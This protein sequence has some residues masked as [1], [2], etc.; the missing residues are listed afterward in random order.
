MHRIYMTTNMVNGKKYVGRCSKD[1]RWDEGYLGSGKILKQ[2]IRKYGY[3]NFKR[4]VLEE[5]PDTASLREAIDLEKVWLLRFDCKNSP[6]YYNMSNDS[7][8]MGA[9]DKHAEETKIKISNSMKEFYG[10]SGLPPEWRENVVNALKGRT[11]WNKGLVF[12]EDEKNA[13][14]NRRTP[15]RLSEDD[16]KQIKELYDTGMTACKIATLWDTSHHV[17][18]GMIRRGGVSVTK[19]RA[20][21]SDEQKQKIAASVRNFHLTKEGK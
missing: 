19:K 8:G 3:E 12:T 4:E 9:G 15:R 1:S 10:D 18:L 11:P 13:Y 14:K 7:G 5:L 20:K 2:A 21:M 6:E 16:Y 17:I